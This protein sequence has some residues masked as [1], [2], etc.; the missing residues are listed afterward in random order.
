MLFFLCTCSVNFQILWISS[1]LAFLWILNNKHVS[2]FNYFVGFFFFFQVTFFP[3]KLNNGFGILDTNE[4]L[5]LAA[6]VSSTQ[7]S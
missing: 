7:P 1:L 5:Q 4:V 6:G 3:N 2:L